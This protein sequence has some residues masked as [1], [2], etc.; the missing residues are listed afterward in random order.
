MTIILTKDKKNVPVE[1]TFKKAP[2]ATE[3]KQ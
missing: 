3:D 1:F 2:K